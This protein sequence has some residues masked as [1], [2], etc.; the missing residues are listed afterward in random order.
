M[1]IR[2]M[3]HH[4]SFSKTKNLNTFLSQTLY[5]DQVR[6]NNPAAFSGL[7][8]LLLKMEG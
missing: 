2:I 8:P 1:N 5:P 7:S 6:L 4:L 3:L